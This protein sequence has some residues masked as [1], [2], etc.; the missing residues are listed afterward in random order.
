M[1]SR[2][3]RLPRRRAW[4][5]TSRP[6]PPPRDWQALL[7]A[8]HH[9]PMS[10]EP[11]GPDDPQETQ[12]FAPAEYRPPPPAP[13]ERI[14]APRSRRP[15]PSLY[16]FLG[17]LLLAGVLIGFVVGHFAGRSSGTAR[18]PSLVLF[19]PASSTTPFAGAQFT[20]STY[21]AQRGICD[22]TRLKQFLRADQ[23]RFQAWVQLVGIDAS[24]FDAFVDRMETARLTSL[25]PVTDHGC[26]T[27]GDCPFAFQ[28]VLAQGTP[29]WRDPAEGHI[30]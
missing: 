26:F 17:L 22:K 27:S 13:T 9:R 30:V 16:A 14:H 18:D 8:L 7:R 2:C 5:S 3:R 11:P 15:P 19:E 28:A 21:D 29:V 12:P 6:C 1:R 20:A 10:H 24:Q 23:R 4:S 25:S